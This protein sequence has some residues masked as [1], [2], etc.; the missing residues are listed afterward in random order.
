MQHLWKRSLSVCGSRSQTDSSMSENDVV[1]FPKFLRRF[2]LP[3]I[4]KPQRLHSLFQ[5]ADCA[6][7]D[8]YDVWRSERNG[9]AH[10]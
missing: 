5:V 8:F 9:V 4:R 10:S 1:T 7:L 3:L 6:N 2:F